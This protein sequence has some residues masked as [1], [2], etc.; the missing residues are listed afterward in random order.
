M[1]HLL[2]SQTIGQIAAGEVIERPLSVV[3]ELV[4]NSIDANATRVEVSIE[5]GGLRSIRVND[6]GEGI[7]PEQLPL[8]VRRHATS[9]LRDACDLES[10]ASLGFRGEG[11]ASIAAVSRTRVVSRTNG[12]EVGAAVEAF[13]ETVGDVEPAAASIGT[14]VEARDLFANVPVRREYLGSPAAEF[15]RISSWLSTFALAYPGV[16]FSL[17]HDGKSVWVM[18]AVSDPQQRL[19][20]VFGKDAAAHL[21]PLNG[22]AARDLHGGVLGFVSEP[23]WDRPDRRMQLL[24]VNG[25]L[26]RS[27]LLAGAWST[28]Y[29][30]FAMVGRNPYGVLFLRLPA[31]HVDANVH[32]TKSDVRLRFSRQVFESV[33]R[34]IA[35]TLREKATSTFRSAVSLAPGLVDTSLAHLQTLFEASPREGQQ[36][37]EYAGAA[38]VRVLGQLAETYVIAT[39]GRTLTLVDQHAAHERIAYES[40][41][42]NASNSSTAEPLLVPLTFELDAEQSEALEA[43]IPLLAEGGLRIEHFGERSYRIVATPGGYR[44]RDFDFRG[45][46]ADLNAVTRAGDVRERLW[47]SVACHSVTRAGE[48][49]E[50]AE[51]AS[52]IERLQ[53]CSN[54]MHCPHGRPTVVRLDEDAL[55]KLFKRI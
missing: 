52:L 19:G 16:T 25:R 1:I 37:G 35:A 28:A 26:L 30:T 50:P 11:L 20:A 14:I 21:L 31:D 54:P 23:G 5:E 27:T 13:G 12:S 29:S 10:I 39:D 2:D 36:P 47:A 51:M 17:S 44:A 34:T 38:R 45:F 32:P 43:A 18:P 48:R 22:N 49:L 24:F 53:L 46:L 3:K 41:V 42:A 4:E 40:I 33:R 15:R 7:P 8:A 55:G 6:D 9:K